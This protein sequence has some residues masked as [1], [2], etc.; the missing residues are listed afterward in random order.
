MSL[1]SYIYKK[2]MID[3]CKSSQIMQNLGLLTKIKEYITFALQKPTHI[4]PGAHV[5]GLWQFEST[6]GD[7]WLEESEYHSIAEQ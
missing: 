5:A 1:E 3:F 4:P 2:L 7:G 6:P